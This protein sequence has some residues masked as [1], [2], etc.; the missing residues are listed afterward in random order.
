[1]DAP[2]P[3]H[4]VVTAHPPLLATVLRRVL[5]ASP[6]SSG[7]CTVEVITL[8]RVPDPDAVHV[9]RLPECSDDPALLESAGTST[10]LVLPT[11]DAV[12][13]LVDRLLG[14]P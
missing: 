14:R 7:A 10:R 9:L 1:M 6:S 11:L 2:L 4:V 3:P 12:T 13:G 8:D 5:S